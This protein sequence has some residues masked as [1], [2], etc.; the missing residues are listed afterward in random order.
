MISTERNLTGN[1]YKHNV[2]RIAGFA[3]C[4]CRSARA[5]VKRK[6]TFQV[7]FQPESISPKVADEIV[8]F[9]SRFAISE[10]EPL[11]ES[12][13]F[14]EAAEATRDGMGV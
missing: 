12:W 14:A 1:D 3:S 8:V 5:T 10:S 4:S 13:L 2:Q 7:A 9:H 6:T 11:F